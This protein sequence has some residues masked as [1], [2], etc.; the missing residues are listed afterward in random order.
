[1]KNYDKRIRPFSE[2]NQPV[3]IK[4]TIVMAILTELVRQFLSF[5]NSQSN[6]S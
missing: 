6:F 3:L 4:M 1:M 5:E 2:A